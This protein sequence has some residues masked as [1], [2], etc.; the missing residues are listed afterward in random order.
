MRRALLLALPLAGAACTFPDVTYADGDA[1][2]GAS[3]S[4][5]SGA[6]PELAGCTAAA[7]QCAGEAGMAEG[8]CNQKCKHGDQPC[9]MQCQGAHGAALGA[10]DGKC[11][12]C[13]AACTSAAGACHAAVEM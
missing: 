13:A 3:T 10:C 11:T 12:S 5:S 9:M 4:S 1:A 7:K 6:C 2:G 8:A